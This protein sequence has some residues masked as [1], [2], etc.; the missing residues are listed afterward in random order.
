MGYSVERRQLLA[1]AAATLSLS[2]CATPIQPPKLVLTKPNVST[3]RVTQLTVCTRPFRE[4]GPRL[5]V[6]K[7]GDKTVVHHYGHGGSGWSLSW[8]SAALV[9]P[10]AMATG[11]KDIAVIGCGAIG[12][13]TAIL[14]QRAGAKVTIYAKELPPNVRSS[15]ASGLWTPDSRICYER[16]ADAELKRNW[17]FMCRHS[18]KTYQS[19]MGLAGDPVE[20]IDS[21]GVRDAQ[22][23]PPPPPDPRPKF[24]DL[25]DELTPD[26][27]VKSQEFAPGEH[28][29][30]A[31]TLRRTKMM[32][33]NIPSYQRLLLNDFLSFGGKIRIKEFH[34][35]AE[36]AELDQNTLVN[37]TGYGARDLFGDN[38]IHPVRGQ[39]ARLIPQ[40]EVSYALFYRRVSFVPR[41]DG[42][43]CQLFKDDYFG[44][45]DA[46]TDPDHAEAQYA[47]DTIAGLFA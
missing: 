11:E 13:T 29:L 14:L 22:P 41:R 18:Y 27:W 20:F 17:E 38:T 37:C 8:G 47:I 21:Y 9:V 4:A 46:S 43:V 30:G 6:E 45:D 24:A 31:H 44:L 36:F 25:A 33:F 3:D 28:N 23:S 2:G 15:L 34:S 12:L 26:L 32:M 5:D 16:N 39:L 1:G 19:L 7:I 42:L 10:K 35:P 40:P